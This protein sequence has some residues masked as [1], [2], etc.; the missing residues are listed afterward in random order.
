MATTFEA[1][2]V[3][4]IPLLQAGD[5]LATVI[6]DSLK[7]AG[8]PLL[9]GDIVVIAQKAISKVENRMVDLGTVTPSAAAETVA[10]QCGKDPR[11]V[12]VILSE[13]TC[14][15][16]TGENLLIVQH[17][18]GA[19]LANAGV[20]R[21]NVASEAGQENVLLLPIDADDSA[22]SV[23]QR[24]NGTS[25]VDVAVIINDSLGRPWRLGTTGTAIGVAGL[26]ALLDLRGDA[27]LFGRELKISVQAIADELS[28][29]AAL[30][31]GQGAEGQ[32][33]IVIRGD[34]GWEQEAGSATDL[35]RPEE[36]DLFR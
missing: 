8:R 3:P 20:D 13:S 9:D 25:G 30:L 28:A 35:I 32:P 31:Q 10:A 34:F 17:R 2:A 6:H 29:T 15:L 21:S 27:D 11:E 16:R 14:V 24:L 4:G 7:A 5:D 12:E 36:M 18:N 23:R 1:F 19:I 22:R 33:V 26:P